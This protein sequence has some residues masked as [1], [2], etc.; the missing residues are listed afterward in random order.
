MPTCSWG[1]ECSSTTAPGS[2]SATDIIIFS[3]VQVAM[4][5]PGKIVW[6]AHCSGVG[7]YWLI[8]APNPGVSGKQTGRGPS[9]PTARTS[10]VVSL[11]RLIAEG[12]GQGEVHFRG[13]PYDQ[14]HGAGVVT[15]SG[16]AAV[17]VL[18]GPAL[19]VDRARDE[20][21]QGLG[22]LEDQL[23]LEDLRQVEIHVGRDQVADGVGPHHH[24]LPGLLGGDHLEGLVLDDVGESHVVE[25]LAEQ[26]PDGELSGLEGDR[27]LVLHTGL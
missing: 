23:L 21:D 27:G 15:D 17:L 9:G 4:W 24:H 3:A 20:A 16:P 10:S 25:E 14:R 13:R 5:T 22:V 6:R 1:W 7:E 26:G 18:A 11:S 19:R 12:P 8:E 2:N